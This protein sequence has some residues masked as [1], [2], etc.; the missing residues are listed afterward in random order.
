MT[1]PIQ[2]ITLDLDDTLWPVDAVITRAE[3]ILQDWMERNAPGTARALP[4]ADFLLYRR[5]LALE[6]PHLSHD[7]TTL[8]RE[9][10][11]RAFAMHGDDPALAESAM[12]VFLTAR[13][14]VEL[15]PD[16]LDALPRLA[17]RYRVVVLTNGN[18]DVERIGIHG[19]FAGVVS[20]RSA[21][22]A[23]PDARIFHLA[24]TLAG[25]P[26][27]H[28][29]HVGDDAELDVRGAAGAGVRTAWINRKR[30]AWPGEPVDKLEFHDLTALCEWLG[31]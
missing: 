7:F 6:L 14:Q 21:G 22:M 16:A 18:A 13:N 24:C 5:A 11:K 4:P 10:L 25:H 19:Y 1:V 20:P 15:F 28:V 23:K 3:Q 8:R 30:F 2:A 26:P 29:L 27:Q 12:E 9:A 17:A 31:V